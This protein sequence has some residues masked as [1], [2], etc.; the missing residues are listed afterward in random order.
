VLLLE[1]ISWKIVAEDI[2]ASSARMAAAAK[3]LRGLARSIDRKN[4][5]L[6]A[7]AAAIR[8]AADA[9]ARAAS[10]AVKVI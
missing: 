1:E 4:K 10:L 7:V 9:A 3:E 5:R 2:A 8:K 6:K